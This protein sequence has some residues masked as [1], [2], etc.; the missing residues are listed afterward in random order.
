MCM[1]GTAPDLSGIYSELASGVRP[2]GQAFLNAGG[3]IGLRCFG[4]PRRAYLTWPVQMRIRSASSAGDTTHGRTALLPSL[5]SPLGLASLS[6]FLR[7]S[8]I[9]VSGSQTRPRSYII[10]GRC[11]KG[12]WFEMYKQHAR[13]LPSYVGRITGQT[14]K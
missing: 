1:L 2:S 9:Q 8:Q 6:L 14:I 3:Y 11:F 5:A 7:S 13:D 10:H 12:L 4:P